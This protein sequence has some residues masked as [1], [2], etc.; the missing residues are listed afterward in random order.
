MHRKK[1]GKGDKNSKNLPN[2]S[3]PDDIADASIPISQ[4]IDFAGYFAWE[5]VL[6]KLIIVIKQHFVAL[7]DN[8]GFNLG[9]GFIITIIGNS[10]RHLEQNWG[11]TKQNNWKDNLVDTKILVFGDLIND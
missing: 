9:L 6:K 2:Q 11:T 8:C 7:I 5:I 10:P 3:K 1:Q 4:S